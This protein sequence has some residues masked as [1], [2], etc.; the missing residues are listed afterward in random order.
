VQANF[1]VPKFGYSCRT[2]HK[3][4][5]YIDSARR[6]DQEYIYKLQGYNKWNNP[7]S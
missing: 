3:S 5:G 7:S 4:S 6:P 2:R 1:G